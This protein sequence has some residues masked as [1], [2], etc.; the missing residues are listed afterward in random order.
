MVMQVHEE[1]RACIVLVISMKSEQ[2]F[3]IYELLLIVFPAGTNY[4]I[5]EHNK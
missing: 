1:H 5:Y 2:K 4:T 3:M